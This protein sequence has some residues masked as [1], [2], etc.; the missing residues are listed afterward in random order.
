MKVAIPT[1]DRENVSEHF[2]RSPNFLVITVEGKEIVSREMRK[3]PGHEE[4]AMKEEHP[5]TDEKGR[6]GSGALA[7]KRH[8]GDHGDN[9]GLE[10]VITGRIGLG[11]YT[12]MKNYG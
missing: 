6:Q 2:G 12:D 1:E 9:Q 11:A 4:F 3:K 7:S 5:Q 8:G 10:L